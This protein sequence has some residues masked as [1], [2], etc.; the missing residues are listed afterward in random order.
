MLIIDVQ[1]VIF[2]AGLEC[3]VDVDNN[4]DL[5]AFLEEAR[6]ALQHYAH[7]SWL[8]CAPRLAAD[9]DTRPT[10]A[11][12][13][14]TEAS[15]S[16]SEPPME[17]QLAASHFC[18]PTFEDFS[19]HYEELQQVQAGTLSES[20][21]NRRRASEVAASQRASVA[22]SPSVATERSPPTHDP[23]PPAASELSAGQQA[24]VGRSL[25]ATARPSLSTRGLTVPATVSLTAASPTVPSPA[26][27]SIRQAAMLAAAA[28]LAAVSHIRSLRHS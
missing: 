2:D 6:L 5:A 22:H 28:H 18:V 17:S 26:G 14:S 4:A 23:P 7:E 15:T 21:F 19:R 3:G 10:A 8:N 12:E 16:Q 27:H 1:E 25:S 13:V 9:M 24:S 20:E 11:M